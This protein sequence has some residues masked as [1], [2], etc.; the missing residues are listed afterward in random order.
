MI[1]LGFAGLSLL[2]AAINDI[3][4]KLYSGKGS[5]LGP[6]IF[7]I[8]AIWTLFFGVLA[9]PQNILGMTAISL[10]WGLLSGLFS[11]LANIML[12]EAMGR[13]E[14]GICATIYRLNLAPAAIFAIAFMGEAFS[15]WKLLGI[16]AAILAV[17]L[18]S[19]SSGKAPRTKQNLAGIWF[20]IGA[21]LLRAGMGITYKYGLNNGADMLMILMLNGVMW[22]ICGLLYFIFLEKHGAK[23]SL[24]SFSFGILS[25]IFVCGI[26]GFMML[27][28]EKG[29]ASIVLPVSQL[30]FFITALLGV[31]FLKEN[32][33]K[34]KSFGLLM[35]LICILFMTMV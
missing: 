10:K 2:C 9:G 5:S 27:A 24:D 11:I 26:A 6:Y 31:I 25:G 32:L 22:M 34:K 7:I 30:S 20:I 23:N 28:L 3:L 21:S 29:D 19:Y 15:L 14:V 4:F 33:T 1:A 16:L 12:I 17:I 8:G 35:A 13:Q 18:F